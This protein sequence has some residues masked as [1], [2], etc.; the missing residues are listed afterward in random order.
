MLERL[1][2]P[3]EHPWAT[4][5]GPYINAL[6]VAREQGDA[7]GAAAHFGRALEMGERLYPPDR[8]RRATRT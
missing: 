2:P 4:L 5:T 3:G 8:Y 6:G 7:A 1:Y